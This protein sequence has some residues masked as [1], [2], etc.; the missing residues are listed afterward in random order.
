MGISRQLTFGDFSVWSLYYSFQKCF[1]PSLCFPYTPLTGRL[2]I[3]LTS[4]APGGCVWKYLALHLCTYEPFVLKQQS[5]SSFEDSSDLFVLMIYLIFLFL[6][7]LITENI[8]TPRIQL[9]S[10]AYSIFYK[11][12]LKQCSPWCQFLEFYIFNSSY[13]LILTATYSNSCHYP[14]LF[15]V[16]NVKCLP[17]P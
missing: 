16:W 14:G 17:T 6:C 1:Y 7:L 5:P 15:F 13:K 4:V 3:F 11:W 10:W 8:E 2:F 9:Y 12:L